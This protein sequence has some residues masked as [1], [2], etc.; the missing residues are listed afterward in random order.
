MKVSV[1][2][3]LAIG[4]GTCALAVISNAAR[5]PRL[6]PGELL[7]RGSEA[8]SPMV[9]VRPR[10]EITTWWPRLR[11]GAFLASRG[12]LREAEQLFRLA[13]TSPGAPDE[14]IAHAHGCVAAVMAA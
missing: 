12:R 3:V 6:K 4:L 5:M 14:V 7:G 9:A 1:Y 8:H 13:S 2:I 11:N 10:A